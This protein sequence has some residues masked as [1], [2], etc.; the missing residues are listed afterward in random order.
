[1]RI[2][3]YF[4]VGYVTKIKAVATYNIKTKFIFALGGAKYNLG[5]YC[6]IFEKDQP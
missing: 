3:H 6:C 4:H 5:C 2:E 1:M